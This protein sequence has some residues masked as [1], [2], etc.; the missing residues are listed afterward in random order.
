[1]NRNPR[2]GPYLLV[3]TIL[4]ATAAV[5][6]SAAAKNPGPGA[7]TV[8]EYRLIY[9]DG[10]LDEM[11]ARLQNEGR[12]GWEYAG[13]IE[14]G[15]GE[16]VLVKGVELDLRD[17]VASPDELAREGRNIIIVARVNGRLYFRVFEADG[18]PVASKHEAEL[19]A[20]TAEIQE[21]AKRLEPLWQADPIS[22]SDQEEVIRAVASIVDHQMKQD[23]A[24][25]RRQCSK[26]TR[27]YVVLKRPRP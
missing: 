20:K 26:D 23:C 4:A 10:E 17:R 21:L 15:T 5:L 24:S 27:R 18:S 22:C 9:P 13:T 12:D 6:G 19:P 3:V 14:R 11:Q 2:I 8:W 1:M 25:C 7:A 16:Q